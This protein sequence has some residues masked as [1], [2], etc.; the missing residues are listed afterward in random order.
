LGFEPVPLPNESL[1]NTLSL[2]ARNGIAV[3]ESQM[4]SIPGVFAG[5]DIV[6]GPSPVLEVVRDARRA[7]EGIDVYL[8]QQPATTRSSGRTVASAAQ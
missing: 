4:T 1:F 6:H 2:N 8:R 5:G 7:A 3:D